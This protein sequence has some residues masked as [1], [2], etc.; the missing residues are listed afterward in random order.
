VIIHLNG[1]LMPPEAAAISPFDRGFVFGD[2]VYEGLRSFRGKLVGM[3]RHIARLRDG[4]RETRIEWDASQ[5]TRITDELIKANNLPDAFIYWQVTRGT[6]GPGQPVRSRVPSGAMTPTVFGYCSAQ[7]PI[8]KFVNAM[9][10]TVTCAT[11]EDTRWTRGHLKSISLLGNVIAALEATEASAQDAVLVRD[12][13]VGEGTAANLVLALPGAGGKI[14]VVTPS[15]ES[16]PILAGVTRA[17]LMQAAPEI[18][19]RPVQIEELHKA[20]EAMLV[21]TTTM[22]TSI[23]ELDGKPVGEGRP[24]PVAVRL[25]KKLT[26]AIAAD[27]G[28]RDVLEK[29]KAD[30]VTGWT[31]SPASASR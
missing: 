26:G 29:L 10:P 24:G 4:L 16:V 12:G 25:L 2:G 8:E 13:L 23:V 28:F 9:P 19:S 15:L 20:S 30:T 1:K 11:T 7:P 18:V 5:L 22:V 6:P 3:D 31:T 17:L 27:L 21:G 14:Q